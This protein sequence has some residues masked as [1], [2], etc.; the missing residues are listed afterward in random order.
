[1]RDLLDASE[2]IANEDGQVKRW[3][4]GDAA[5]WELPDEL[6]MVLLEIELFVGVFSDKLSPAQ[7]E[8][9]TDLAQA[10]VTFHRRP[11]GWRDPDEIL[12]DPSW[13]ILRTKARK[14]VVE[15]KGL[16]V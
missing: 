15:F 3:L 12:H 4:A 10:A 2:A 1:M 6:L 5:S 7:V 14:F 11:G 8:A 16:S 13:Q 9:A